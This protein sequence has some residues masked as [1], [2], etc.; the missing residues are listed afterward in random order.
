MNS[1]VCGGEVGVGGG[2]GE[3]LYKP[4]KVTAKHFQ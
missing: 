1:T 3:R 2:E 4:L